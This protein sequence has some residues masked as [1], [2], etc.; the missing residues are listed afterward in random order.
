MT[1]ALE[2]AA[3]WAGIA[4]FTAPAVT[5]EEIPRYRPA[6]RQVFN[7]VTFLVGRRKRPPA[8]ALAGAVGRWE[9][10]VLP[11]WSATRNAIGECADSQSPMQD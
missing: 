7:V 4:R 6:R 1:I 9:R 2:E 5:R 11:V 8:R 3:A 10:C